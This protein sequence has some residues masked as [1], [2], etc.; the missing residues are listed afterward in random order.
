MWDWFGYFNK[1]VAANFLYPPGR[2]YTPQGAGPAAAR[3]SE[4]ARDHTDSSPTKNHLFPRNHHDVEFSHR[5]V[6]GG[7]TVA[8]GVD[9]ASLEHGQQSMVGIFRQ[10][11]PVRTCQVQSF[12][13]Q[14][15]TT[16]Q[17]HSNLAHK[18]WHWHSKLGTE[19]L[20]QKI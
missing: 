10:F 12:Q 5:A 2:F 15:A 14:F 19:N 6:I 17:I 13:S 9:R 1:S 20:A 11:W 7:S 8:I 3:H 4:P 16:K 18:T